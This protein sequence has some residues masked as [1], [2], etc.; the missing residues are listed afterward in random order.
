MNM[1]RK[2]LCRTVFVAL[3]AFGLLT[4]T[5]TANLSAGEHPTTEHPSKDIDKDKD[6]QDGEHPSKEH[7]G[8]DKDKDKDKED[9][10]HP[11]KDKEKQDGEHPGKE[12]GEH[13]SK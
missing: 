5:G 10:E 11:G 12:D 8:K 7:P 13:P 3:V 9:G 6:K 1:T 2:L 4:W